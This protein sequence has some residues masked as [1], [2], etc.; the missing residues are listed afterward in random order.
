MESDHAKVSFNNLDF[1]IINNG[2]TQ[3]KI[4]A[5]C[6]CYRTTFTHWQVKEEELTNYEEEHSIDVRW[7]PS[8]N[9]YKETQKLL[10][11]RSY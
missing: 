11:E 5:V 8:S 2:Y 7:T 9:I 10:V 1:D 6:T 4:A 3:N